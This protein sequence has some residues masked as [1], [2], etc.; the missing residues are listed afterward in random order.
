M[1]TVRVKTEN[2]LLDNMDMSKRQTKL[3]KDIKKQK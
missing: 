3:E 2:E 1:M